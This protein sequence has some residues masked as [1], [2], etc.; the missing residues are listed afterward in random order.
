MYH[1]YFFIRRLA[2][3][4]RQKI[5][6]WQLATCFSQSKEELIIGL[7]SGDMDFYLKCNLDPTL[8][9]I[10]FSDNFQRARRNS[11]D[12]FLPVVGKE[13][14]DVIQIPFDRSFY[15]LFPGD[16]K[17]LFK[18][19]GRRGNI[20]LLGQ[21]GV[22]E[23]FRKKLIADQ[24]ITVEQLTRVIDISNPSDKDIAQLKILLGGSKA[25]DYE[26][27]DLLNH[28]NH[29]LRAKEYFLSDDA[30]GKPELFFS[31]QSSGDFRSESPI[32]TSNEYALRLGQGYLFEREKEKYLSSLSK[33]INQATRYISNSKKELNRI[34][35]KRSYEEI[36]NIIMANLHE[37]P[38][39]QEE[40]LLN[41]VYASGKVLVKIR[42]GKSP[43][44][45]AEGLY[46]KSKNERIQVQKIR[47][48]IEKKQADID[49][50]QRIIKEISASESWKTLKRLIK[51]HELEQSTSKTDLP[52]PYH[53]F[54]FMGFRIL[55]GKNA[56]ANDELSFKY[57]QKDDLWL[58]ARDVAG[59]H[60]II[61]NP[62]KSTI[63][64][65]V[66]E[67]AA[68]L[69]AYYS[70]RKNDSLS[71]VIVTPRKYVRKKKGLPPGKVMVEKEEVVMVKPEK[72]A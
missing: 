28:V 60:V 6:G 35:Q 62:A 26:D 70:K 10:S 50:S 11:V 44:K 56:K 16:L 1:S 12:L 69:A 15:L 64:N 9:L 58:H 23:V 20:L 14:L 47:E 53:E 68:S 24:E 2:E 7:T 25:G 52:L 5:S 37:I 31:A 66:V 67:K 41:D 55:V 51:T 63:P 57:A 22:L 59:S 45:Y 21:E 13:V 72:P 8:G 19:H 71:P 38:A 4:L 29:L 43:Q 36:A 48:N 33:R 32:E 46:K 65:P 61:K 18:M 34:E 49:T 40:V 27:A 39:G 30:K 3:E 17:L 54:Q 42:G